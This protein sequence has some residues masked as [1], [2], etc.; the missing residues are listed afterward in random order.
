MHALAECAAAGAAA[1]TVFSLVTGIR[2]KAH[3]I[4]VGGLG[5]EVCYR[6]GDAVGRVV[7]SGL[8]ALVRAVVPHLIPRRGVAV[9]FDD[10]E[11]NARLCRF[12]DLCVCSGAICWIVNALER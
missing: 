5:L 11:P 6:D 12:C 8:C 2:Y 3:H 1:N 10:Y 4:S 9:A 7:G